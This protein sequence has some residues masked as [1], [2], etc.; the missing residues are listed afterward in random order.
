MSKTNATPDPIEIDCRNRSV[1][2]LERLEWLVTN[3]LGSY[4]SSTVLGA[5]TRRYHGLLVASTAPPVGRQVVLSVLCESAH[6][7]PTTL[8]MSSYQFA[9]AV[10]PAG[11]ENLVRFVNDVAPTWVFAGDDITVTR[12][13]TLADGANTLAVRYKVDAPGPVV[14][15]IRPLA[16]L[17]DFH[18]LRQASKPHQLLFSR[19][20]GGVRVED[21]Q[22]GSEPLWI[23]CEGA[24]FVDEP[25]WWYRFRYPVDIQRG[26]EGLEDLYSPGAFEVACEPGRW[27]RLLAACQR[28]EGFDF[29]TNIVERRRRRE[30]LAAAVGSDADETTR[31]LAAACDDFVVTRRAPSGP[32]ATI[33]AGYHWFADWGRDSFIALPGVALLTGRFDKARQILDTF[34]HAIRD[35]MI[36]NRFDDYGGSPHYNSIDASLWFIL[37]VDRYINA[38]GD[39]DS[40]RQEFVGPVRSILQS[41]HDGAQFNIHAG[42][43]GLLVGG[44][45]N[46]QLTWMDVK[47]NDQAITPRHGMA[48]EINAL[49]LEAMHIAAA[50]CRGLDAEA[51]DHYT[52]EADRIAKAFTG[53]FWNDEA[54]C[55]YD[56]ITP[57][58]P[59][60]ALRPNQ[61]IAVAMP[62]C[63]LS[64]DRQQRV[65]QVVIDNLLT[66]LGLRTLAP[67]AKL[68][69]GRY[70]GSWESRDRAYH[71]GTVWA[72]LMGPLVQAYLRVNDFSDDARRQAAKWLEPFDEHLLDA[73]LGTISEIFDG[74]PPHA[75]RGCIAQAWS[76]AEVLRA[77]MMVQKGYLL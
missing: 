63:P 1:D 14:L 38:S 24:T 29:E 46:T 35:G 61:I 50:R 59:D 56:C 19:E 47:F 69:R 53:T 32:S 20:G 16:A 62:H 26:Q 9:G 73:G 3:K 67:S 64:A 25:Q 7:G 15:S 75:P 60:P 28:T 41:Y 31:R 5:N 52:A 49:W 74:D 27:V 68:Y 54:G 37:A 12:Q 57:E 76:V 13:L 65:V 48:V 51:A 23:G 4:A 21:R 36:P 71:Q 39:V 58:G 2:E 45:S 66:P 44:S 6:R 43:S 40:W 30:E 55:L 77:K 11:S 42:A 8:E 18:V 34:A 17:R 33:L 70:G 22:R 10:S 72:W